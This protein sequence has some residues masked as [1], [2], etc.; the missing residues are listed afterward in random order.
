ML[1]VYG[2][3]C[4]INHTACF[5]NSVFLWWQTLSG[6]W[7]GINDE[8]EMVSDQF[9]CYWFVDFIDDLA[10]GWGNNLYLYG[11]FYSVGL[12]TSFGWFAITHS[13][14]SIKWVKSHA[15]YNNIMYVCLSKE[16]K[17]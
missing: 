15:I 8:I 5:F 6:E 4:L 9:W 16:I 3:V 1:I 13:S 17:T 7:W 2:D 14:C 11:F 12:K 10:D